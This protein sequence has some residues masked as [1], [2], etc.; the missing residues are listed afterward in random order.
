MVLTVRSQLYLA[1]LN[2]I[3]LLCSACFLRGLLPILL[4][5]DIHDTAASRKEPPRSSVDLHWRRRRSPVNVRASTAKRKDYDQYTRGYQS[6][7]WP[8]KHSHKGSSERSCPPR[9][10]LERAVKVDHRCGLAR[11][12]MKI[13]AHERFLF[14]SL[15]VQIRLRPRKVSAI[16]HPMLK[17]PELPASIPSCC[18]ALEILPSRLDADRARYSTRA[19]AAVF[20]KI[21]KCV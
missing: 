19:H 3:L 6:W 2:K 17:P 5:N 7:L 16:Q 12:R 11:K 4:R 1:L 13:H 10:I 18:V 21:Y 15:E 14:F 8:L 20:T 9:E